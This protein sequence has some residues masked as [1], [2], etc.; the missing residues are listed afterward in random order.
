MLSAPVA[1]GSPIHQGS[2]APRGVAANLPSLVPPGMRA[3]TINVDEGNS[4]SGMLTPGCHVDVVATFAA[5]KAKSQTRS[6]GV[7]RPDPGH[8]PTPGRRQ[9][10]KTGRNRPLITRPLWIV[11]PRDAQMI[12]L[13]VVSARLRLLLRPLNHGNGEDNGS[14]KVTM[15]E[16]TGADDA[17]P[18]AAV[19][20]P[21]TNPSTNNDADESCLRS[22]A[23]HH[24][25]RC[26]ADPWKT[27]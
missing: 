11:S 3:I 16:L 20:F 15:A 23:I 17:K 22:A 4:L 24:Q 1:K 14:E 10:P 5:G 9:R 27:S 26:D 7:Q 6:A 13:A 12:D 18:T 8:W 19:A 2:L 21:T 25:P